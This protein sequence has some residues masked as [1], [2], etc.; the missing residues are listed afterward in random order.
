MNIYIKQLGNG[1]IHF[2]DLLEV[3]RKGSRNSAIVSVVVTNRLRLPN[4]K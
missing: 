2:I 4:V 1:Q 3:Y